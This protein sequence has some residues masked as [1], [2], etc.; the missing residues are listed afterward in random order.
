MLRGYVVASRVQVYILCGTHV[1]VVIRH[2][3]AWGLKIYPQCHIDNPP[4]SAAK[5][6][7]T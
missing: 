6:I 5:E 2:E 3:D 4:C 7:P 1:W